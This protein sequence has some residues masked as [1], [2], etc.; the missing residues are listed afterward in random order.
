MLAIQ[1]GD[2]KGPSN[3][4]FGSKAD[5]CDSQADV[6]FGPIADIPSNTLKLA[7]DP[8]PRSREL[9]NGASIRLGVRKIL[10]SRN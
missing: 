5:M 4:R 1:M 6:R 3:V 8:L 2:R 7:L 10:K 9:S